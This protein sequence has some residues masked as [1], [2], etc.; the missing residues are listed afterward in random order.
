[1]SFSNFL[2]RYAEKAM[3]EAKN[4]VDQ[5]VWTMKDYRVFTEYKTN[6]DL[7]KTNQQIDTKSEVTKEKTEL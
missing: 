5:K 2:E 3:D 1:M 6:H 4:L 7:S